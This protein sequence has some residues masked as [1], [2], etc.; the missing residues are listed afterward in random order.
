LSLILLAYNEED[1]IRAAIDDHMR[2]ANHALE[3]FEIIVVDDGSTDRTAEIV[4]EAILEH[5]QIRLISHRTNLGMG[6]GMRSG[7]GSATKKYLIFNASDGQIAA[8]EIG[9]LLPLLANADIV[10]STYDTKRE[11]MTR[12]L[13]SRGFRLFLGVTANIRFSLEGLYLFPTATAKALAPRIEANTFFFSFG[14]IQL[15]IE[16]G[17]STATTA[18]RLKPRL[19]GTSKVFNFKRIQRVGSDV[20]TFSRRK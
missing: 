2:F 12:E 9:K 20:F 1:N 7:I 14:L 10:L 19:Q 16:K 8:D 6:G 3:D 18:I 15:G 17:L 11:N 13:V 4:Q 5:S